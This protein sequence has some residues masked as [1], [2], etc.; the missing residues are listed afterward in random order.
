VSVDLSAEVLLEHY[1]QGFLWADED[2]LEV[3]GASAT[4]W[5]ARLPQTTTVAVLPDGRTKWRIRTRIV[6]EI[7]DGTG[8]HQLCAA[9]NSHAAGWSFAYDEGEGTVDAIAAICALPQWDTFFLRLSE[10]AKLSAWMS[11]VIAERLAETLGGV[12]AFSHPESQSGLR[13]RYDGTYHYLENM[14]GRPEWVL[15]P[16]RYQFPPIEDIAPT[17]AG[18]VG[19]DP[20]AVWSDTHSLRIMIGPRM[21]LTAGFDTHPIFGDGWR[22]AL[23]MPGRPITET[24]A[25]HLSTITWMLFE[26]PDT[27]LLGGWTNEADGLTFQQWNTMSEVRNQEQLGSYTDHSAT[28]LW[29]FTS[30]LSDA[31]GAYAETELPEDGEAGASS[32]TAD[33][34]EYVIAAIAEQAR[35]AVTERP[36]EGEGTAD[37]RLLWLEHRETLT[38]AAWFNPAGPTVGSIEV[39]ALPDG[40]EYLVY[41]RR[42]P[43]APYYRVLGPIT[44]GSDASQMHSDAADLLIGESLPNVLALWDN[45]G[46]AAADVPDVIRARILIAADDSGEELPAAAAWIQQTMGNPWEF[47]AVDQSEA[48][49]VQAAAAE[50]AAARPASDG[51]FAEWWDQVSSF[52]NIVA[53]FRCLPD[54]WDGALN[55]QGAFGNLGLF[56]V[57]PLPLTYSKI[58]MPGT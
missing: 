41:F 15:D 34:A 50:A 56:D 48:D 10:K 55:T 17:I 14:R 22:S 4:Y 23:K 16:T 36:A 54:A 19:T 45:P 5:Q 20:D 18:M 44:D 13:E 1:L 47:A 9:L 57:G 31:V 29:G 35:P 52:E 26:N 24:M 3:D 53:N 21:G 49:R 7:P 46:S 25:E 28:D 11:D 51:G 30:T 40:T 12:P 39:C 58:G 8:A 43:F 42:H 33:R 2:W 38:V 32:D 6:E 37:R 27:N